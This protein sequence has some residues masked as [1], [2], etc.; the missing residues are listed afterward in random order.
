MEETIGY[1]ALFSAEEWAS[2]DLFEWEDPDPEPP[3]HRVTIWY[4]PGEA[5]GN[6]R[7]YELEC[8]SCGLIAATESKDE[9]DLVARLHEVVGARRIDTLEVGE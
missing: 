2:L 5:V 9:A 6:E 1:E 3:K 8:E 4:P 7:K